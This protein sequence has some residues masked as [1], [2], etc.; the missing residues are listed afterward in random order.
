MDIQIVEYIEAGW[1]NITGFL[2]SVFFTA[3]A[4]SLA[5]AFAG[6]HAAQKIAE[7]SKLREQYLKEIRGTNTAIELAFGICNSFISLKHQQVKPLK[8]NFEA[9]KKALEELLR[10]RTLGL[11]SQDEALPFKAELEVIP[12]PTFPIGLLQAEVFEKSAPVGR[13]IAA[14]SML[15]QTIHMLDTAME[16]RNKLIDTYIAKTFVHP[17][18]YFGFQSAGKTNNMYPSLVGTIY[19]QTNH[20][21]FF[22]HL[23]CLDLTKHGKELLEE[24]KK[25]FKKGEPKINEFNFNRANELGLMPDK[26]EYVGWLSA[27]E[28]TPATSGIK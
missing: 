10:K 2:N 24:Y 22:S 27:F 26:A 4:G 9:S 25:L 18:E 17:D 11:I 6:A 1:G 21:I 28:N 19:E 7:R 20:G 5:G 16:M 23:L 14:L 12:L 8:E 15:S 13:P 3:I